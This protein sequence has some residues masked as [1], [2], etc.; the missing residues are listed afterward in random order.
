MAGGVEITISKLE[1]PILKN[2]VTKA[3]CHKFNYRKTIVKTSFPI[4]FISI[5]FSFPLTSVVD[6][7]TPPMQKTGRKT[8]SD[9]GDD[10]DGYGSRHSPP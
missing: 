5:S 6:L 4:H 7:E 3:P 8:P 2:R 1:L 9:D 10:D